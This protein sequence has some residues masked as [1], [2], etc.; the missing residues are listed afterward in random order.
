[1]YLFSKKQTSSPLCILA[2][3]QYHLYKSL[4]IETLI[5]QGRYFNHSLRVPC[6]V[7]LVVYFYC[8][9]LHKKSL[10]KKSDKLLH[11]TMPFIQLCT[12]LC[13]SDSPYMHI[14]IK[15]CFF[16]QRF[17]TPTIPITKYAYKGF[18]TTISC[19]LIKYALYYNTQL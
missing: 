4:N 19:F 13:A 1:M 2:L 12:M 18:H 10:S 11:Y 6:I 14:K 3:I 8:I 16:L 17:V 15:L 9:K 5:E 7:A